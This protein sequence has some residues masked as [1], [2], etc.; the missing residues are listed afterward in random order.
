MQRETFNQASLF[1]M[2]M[3]GTKRPRI[4]CLRA[5]DTGRRGAAPPDKPDIT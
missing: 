5:T 3:A 4:A 1:S 2:L